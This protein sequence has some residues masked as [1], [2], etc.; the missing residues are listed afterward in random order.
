MKN[1]PVF[2]YEKQKVQQWWVWA[3]MIVSVLF[4]IAILGYL[5]FYQIFTKA[6]FN[7]AFRIDSGVIVFGMLNAILLL[8]SFI[9]FSKVSLKVELSSL[10]LRVGF[11]FLM[12][13]RLFPIYTIRNFR[14]LDLQKNAAFSGIGFTGTTTRRS[15]VMD[16]NNAIEFEFIDGKTLILGTRCPDEFITT[17]N[18]LV[19]K[20]KIYEKD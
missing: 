9:L 20:N 10:G 19:L 7:I 2:F 11:F 17:L 12:P 3:I 4:G 15:I 18:Y 5:I 14:L 16:G 1:T 13:S 8:S 6:I